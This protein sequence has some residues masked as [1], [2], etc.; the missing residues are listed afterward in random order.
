MLDTEPDVAAEDVAE[1]GAAAVPGGV[2]AAAVGVGG[3]AVTAPDAKVLQLISLKWTVTTQIHQTHEPCFCRNTD[4]S[5]INDFLK[6]NV[7]KITTLRSQLY[8][9]HH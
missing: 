5:L 6:S 4:A 3:A 7:L 9:T 1:E 2:A 8:R